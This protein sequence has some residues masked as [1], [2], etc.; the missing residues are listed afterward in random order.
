M[1]AKHLCWL[2][3]IATQS[4]AAQPQEVVVTGNA[5]RPAIER[6]LNADNVD[7][8]RLSVRQIADVMDVIHRGSAPLDFWLAYREHVQ[9]WREYAEAKDRG[10]RGSPT[11]IDQMSDSAAIVDAR[12]RI[13]STF[14][15]VEAIARR[16]G[17]RVP[18]SRP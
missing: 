14:D 10:Q 16:Y 6:I 1:L 18:A 5:A 7:L 8:D 12:R 15:K 3:A 2:A 13:N 4:P 11:G 17:A 9:A